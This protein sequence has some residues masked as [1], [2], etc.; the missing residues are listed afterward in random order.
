M[1]QA[2]LAVGE[3][4]HQVLCGPFASGE[5]AER[6][7]EEKLRAQ[8]RRVVELVRAPGGGFT[9]E[10]LA[11]VLGALRLLQGS[12]VSD[13]DA[14]LELPHF[15]EVP[16]LGEYDI[17]QLCERINTG[18]ELTVQAGPPLSASIARM[19]DGTTRVEYRLI[20]GGATE[21]ET[22][23]VS[24]A[25][26]SLF[27]AEER[28]YWEM[29]EEAR[30]RLSAEGMP[31]PTTLGSVLGSV[32]QAP[33]DVLQSWMGDVTV[34]VV[35]ATLSELNRLIHRWGEGATVA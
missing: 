3:P 1:A 26:L 24:D 23:S 33:E 2:V 16:P 35:D 15:E 5:A 17:D 29:V 7:G 10:E 25:L 18:E 9:D 4:G 6:F 28:N 31:P 13:L 20:A 30:Q 19:E 32:E 14:V 8:R 34:E 27:R 22:V 21:T 11:T 12:L